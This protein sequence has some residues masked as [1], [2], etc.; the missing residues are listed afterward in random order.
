M[1]SGSLYKTNSRR[2]FALTFCILRNS[3]IPG[4][5]SALWV[6]PAVTES[7]CNSRA[8]V[9]SP[10]PGQTEN[11]ACL[12][13]R[14]VAQ[15]LCQLY[16]EHQLNNPI[17]AQD[18]VAKPPSP[19]LSHPRIAAAR[20]S[21]PNGTWQRPLASARMPA[22][23]PPLC[24]GNDCTQRAE[25]RTE[26]RKKRGHCAAAAGGPHLQANP[27]VF[28]RNGTSQAAGLSPGPVP[29]LRAGALKAL[30]DLLRPTEASPQ[31]FL[32]FFWPH[33]LYE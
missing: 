3:G 26:R 5:A 9:T 18:S 27:G 1:R 10:S 32:L 16:Q 33:G 15:K 19:S 23:T 30:M 17:Q 2:D 29:F 4:R 12:S 6:T 21:P 14:R 28:L 7:E 31:G 20:P 8:A 24:P 11:N 22:L 25:D 13:G